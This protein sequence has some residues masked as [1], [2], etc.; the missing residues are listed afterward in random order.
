MFRIRTGYYFGLPLVALSSSPPDQA[1]GVLVPARSSRGS[2]GLQRL[3]RYLDAISCLL[4][5][6]IEPDGRYDVGY[7]CHVFA[8]SF[9]IPETL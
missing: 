1:P 7:P 9:V 6:E 3:V 4:V 2:P 5:R 8:L